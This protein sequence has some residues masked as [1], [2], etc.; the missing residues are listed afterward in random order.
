MVVYFVGI[1]INYRGTLDELRGCIN[2]VYNIE[3]TLRAKFPNLQIQILTDDTLIKPT[4]KNILNIWQKTLEKAQPGDIVIFS[5][6]GHGTYIKD[7]NNDESDK[8]DE[9]LYTIDQQLIIDDEI[10]NLFIRFQKPNVDILGIFDS[11]FSGTVVDLNDS[12][13]PI[14]KNYQ[15]NNKQTYKGQIVSISGSRDDQTSADAFLD[16]QFSGAMTWAFIQ[17]FNQA[18][19]WKG[20]IDKMASKL[21]SSDF[22]QIPILSYS[23]NTNINNSIY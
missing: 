3:K 17:Y 19:S 4:R 6:S 23:K 16:N 12:Y 18:K 13:I 8:R 21:K 5:F 7:Q 1:G 22:S 10:N 9:A 20:L 11:C 14:D 2:D 15:I